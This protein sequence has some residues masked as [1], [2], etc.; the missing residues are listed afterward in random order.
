MPG[1]SRSRF[2]SQHRRGS[3]IG[4]HAPDACRR[5][6]RSN[7]TNAPSPRPRAGPATRRNG[8]RRAVGPTRQIRRRCA[9]CRT[10]APSANRRPRHANART[11]RYLALATHRRCRAEHAV[12][13]VAVAQERN[14]RPLD[15]RARAVDNEPLPSIAARRSPEPSANPEYRDIATAARRSRIDVRARTEE[16]AAGSRRTTECSWGNRRDRRAATPS[17]A[18][19]RASRTAR[20]ATECELRPSGEHE[21]TRASRRRRRSD[22]LEDVAPSLRRAATCPSSRARTRVACVRG[23]GRSTSR[24]GSSC[25]PLQRE[26]RHGSKFGFAAGAAAQPGARSRKARRNR[27]SAKAHGHAGRGDTLVAIRARDSAAAGG[28]ADSGA[29]ASCRCGS[30]AGPTQRYPSFGIVTMYRA[31]LASSPNAARSSFTTWVS[32]SSDEN[33]P[34]HTASKISRRVTVRVGSAR[35]SCRPRCLRVRLKCD[36]R[37]EPP[38]QRPAR[39]YP[40]GACGQ[41]LGIATSG[42]RPRATSRPRWDHSRRASGKSRRMS[43]SHTTRR[44][45]NGCGTL[46]VEAR[47]IERADAQ[48]AAPRRIH[49]K[50]GSARS[51]A[52][53]GVQRSRVPR[54]RILRRRGAQTEP[55]LL[56]RVRDSRERAV[57]DVTFLRRARRRARDWLHVALQTGSATCAMVHRAPAQRA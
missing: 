25:R 4:L 37:H 45:A 6:L 24:P 34:G 30:G 5:G 12:H 19:R 32:T 8:S 33:E 9:R 2:G 42:M 28:S 47:G 17:S 3:P 36:P 52:R 38:V 1:T 50:P 27:N 43:G 21:A 56:C 39:R 31:S 40:R 10:P 22:R 44:G 20:Y 16:I 55:T 29:V 41:G 14:S 49:P 11:Q 35:S 18:R 54:A 46:C 48:P 57:L 51:R 26:P 7:T 53:L 13:A 23:E 15:P